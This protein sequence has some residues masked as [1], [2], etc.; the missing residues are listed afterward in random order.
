LQGIEKYKDKYDGA[1][2]MVS[3]LPPPMADCVRLIHADCNDVD[4]A[5][6]LQVGGVLGN[7]RPCKCCT[8]YHCTWLSPQAEDFAVAVVFCNNVAFN[9]G[10]THR[11]GTRCRA[12]MKQLARPD[13]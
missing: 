1:Q 4:L 6:M 2:G 7:V 8:L 13:R 11:F 3:S 9:A 12:L 10:T 5:E